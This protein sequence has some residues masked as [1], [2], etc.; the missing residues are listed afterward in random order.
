MASTPLTT[1]HINLEI[2][3]WDLTILLITLARDILRAM[4]SRLPFDKQLLTTLLGWMVWILAGL[5]SGW[6]LGVTSR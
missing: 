2:V 5:S 1:K 4:P 6:V 3:F